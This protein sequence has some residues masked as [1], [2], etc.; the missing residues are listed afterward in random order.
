MCEL[1][2]L[3]GTKFLLVDY[4]NV[5]PSLTRFASDTAMQFL[6]FVGPHQEKISFELVSLLQ[7]L[8]DRAR[9]IKVVRQGT[10]ALDFHIA[11]FAGKISESQPDASVIIISND[12]GYDSM[13][14][15]MRQSGFDISREG[16][17]MGKQKP[18]RMK[19]K[20]LHKSQPVTS[21]HTEKKLSQIN[22]KPGPEVIESVFVSLVAMEDHPPKSMKALKSV[23]RS[24][25]QRY[26]RISDAQ[27]RMII[28]ILSSRGAIR[29]KGGAVT[30]S[31]S[32]QSLRK[33]A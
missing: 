26:G 7:S 30:C 24:S 31:I 28:S 9:Y 32:N 33:S 13:I 8:G 27:M 18:K 14:G 19:G 1:Y 3:K 22:A 15:F 4:E 6:V 20:P 11:L 17:Q 16:V 21:N 2:P 12:K 25:T 5:Q 29:I 23:I 10:N